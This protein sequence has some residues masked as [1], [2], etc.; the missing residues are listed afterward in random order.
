[1]KKQVNKKKLKKI[2]TIVISIILTLTIIAGSA[3]FIA[4]YPDERNPIFNDVDK[5]PSKQVFDEGEFKMG[6]H[7]LIVSVTGDDTADGTLEAPLKTLNG[8]KEKLKSLNIPKEK[9]VTVWF[10]EGT[11]TFT[12]KVI[13]DNTDKNNVLY[14][15]Y[16]D[17]EVIFSGSKEINGNWKE[18]EINDVKAFVTDIDIKSDN[19]YFRS[20][21]KAGK[22]LSRPN[23]PKEGLLKVKD[24][25]LDE[26]IVPETDPDYFTHSAAF[27][28]HTSDLKNFSNIEDIDIRIMHF[29][30]DELLPVHSIDSKTGRIE[31]RKPTS[32]TIRVDDNYIL[33][34]VKEALTLPG[35]WYLDRN[36]GKLYYIPEENDTVE[37]TVLY[38]GITEQLITIANVKN[39]SFQGINFEKTDWDYTGKDYGFFGKAFDETHPLYKNIEYSAV[40]PQAAFETPAAI[41]INSSEN[42]NFTNCN[43]ENISYSAVKFEKAS[44]NCN[45]TS[46][47]FNEIGGNAIFINGEF[48]VPAS[49][50]NINVTDC[51]ISNYG[52]IFNNAIGILLTHAIDC[53]LT[54]N[55]IH[56]GWYTGISVGWNWGYTDNPTNNIN[57]SDNLIYNIGNGWL[58]DMGGIYTLGIQP[59]T[60]ISKNVIYNVGC[61]EGAYGYGGWGI[62]LDEGSS[63][64]LVEK[65]L[66]YDCSSQ[67]F[68][69]HY[70]KDNMIK[71]NI[72]AFGGEGQ[73]RITRNE[74]H[75]SLFLYNNIL[76]GDDTPMY[77]E[78]TGLDWFKDDNNLYW[79]YNTFG[80]TVYSGGST[81]IFNSENILGMYG[82]GY[83]NNAVLADPLFKDAENRDFTLADNSPAI[84]AGFEP[85]DY[86]AGTLTQF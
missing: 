75:N 57:I 63:E 31:T 24:P 38:A 23:Y 29:W 81:N 18:T 56:D 25:K 32:M 64:I 20:L 85:F 60:V 55:E 3:A 5:K 9:N 71:N 39:I 72:F 37:N 82:R 83:Y 86:D 67:T 12:D 43:F 59:D 53:N 47:L 11:Y 13:F 78:T 49:T 54:N 6:E 73:F 27:Y 33:E 42:I 61:D 28:A 52:R 74:D 77:W 65:N 41:Y 68:H 2:V 44:Q 15:S 69:Q 26:A 70:G 16:P 46:C 40:H 50:K 48:V 22:R 17:E 4:N 21:F 34:N 36:E 19:D 66:V 84:D 8:A 10:R 45:I 14:R 1:M 7:D 58:S 80:K 51:H 79:D 30:C 76:V 35:E 62:Y